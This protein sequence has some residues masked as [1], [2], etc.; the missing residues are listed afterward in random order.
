ALPDGGTG[1]L[2]G[3]PHFHRPGSDVAHPAVVAPMADE[4]AG[5]AR[6]MEKSPCHPPD[7]IRYPAAQPVG[8]KIPDV[9]DE[10][11]APRGRIS[12]GR[13]GHGTAHGEGQASRTLSFQVDGE[14]AAAELRD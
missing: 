5:E 8:R 3:H 4:A 11:T 1:Q 2:T 7:R 9:H 14:N 10:G 6:E 12:P 13:L